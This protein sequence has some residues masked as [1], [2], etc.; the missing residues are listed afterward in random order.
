MQGNYRTKCSKTAR[1]NA[2]DI[3]Y[4]RNIMRGH[5]SPGGCDVQTDL[6]ATNSW[7][8]LD[9]TCKKGQTNCRKVMTHHCCH[10]RQL[11][12]LLSNDLEMQ[13]FSHVQTQLYLAPE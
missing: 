5:T 13:C 8:C 12:K 10:D 4:M 6:L 7:K 3:L 1:K 2:R 9:K 11:S